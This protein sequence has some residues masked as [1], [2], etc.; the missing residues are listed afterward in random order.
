LRTFKRDCSPNVNR[1]N[2]NHSPKKYTWPLITQEYIKSH[3]AQYESSFGKA[4]RLKQIE[5][6]TLTWKVKQSYLNRVKLHL[7]SRLKQIQSDFGCDGGQWCLALNSGDEPQQNFM[8]ENWGEGA[9]EAAQKQKEEEVKLAHPKII[10][11]AVRTLIFLHN[12]ATL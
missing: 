10:E 5:W 7:Q 4:H 3:R 12:Y 6:N 8:P 1:A 11:T 9:E 2:Q